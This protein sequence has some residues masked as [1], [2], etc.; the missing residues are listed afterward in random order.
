[1]KYIPEATLRAG[2]MFESEFERQAHNRGNYV[3]RHCDQLG[4]MGTKAPMVTGP[5]TGYRLPDFSLIPPGGGMYWAE[6][7]RKSKAT[8]T[9]IT[10]SLDHGIDLPNWHDYLTISKISKQRGYLIIGEGDTGNI[11][12][13]PFSHLQVCA[14]QWKGSCEAFPDGAVFWPREQFKL[15]GHF[16]ISNGQISFDF[17]FADKEVKHN[18]E[19]RYG[20]TG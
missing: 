10:G 11:L 16:D 20:R 7:K 12:I 4:V 3:V 17:G 6:A 1:M 13:A 15:W 5:Y 14:R 19:E 8:Y 2:R 18:M 9:A